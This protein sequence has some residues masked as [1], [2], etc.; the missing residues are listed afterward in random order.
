MQ[1]RPRDS[2]NVQE[3]NESSQGVKYQSAYLELQKFEVLNYR[4]F[5]IRIRGIQIVYANKWKV[6]T[7][8]NFAILSQTKTHA[9]ISNQGKTT[10]KLEEWISKE[11]SKLSQNP[12]RASTNHSLF[13]HSPLYFF[14]LEETVAL[15]HYLRKWS[16]MIQIWTKRK[17]NE[18]SS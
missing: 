7:S 10:A 12:F 5:F 18:G 13:L 14:I 15:T 11:G 4:N 3:L 1:C 6:Y 16:L 2:K 9:Q 17:T 8:R